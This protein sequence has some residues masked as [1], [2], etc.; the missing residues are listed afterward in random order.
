MQPFRITPRHFS[1]AVIIL[2]VVMFSAILAY[3]SSAWADSRQMKLL[4]HSVFESFLSLGIIVASASSLYRYFEGNGWNKPILRTLGIATV[5]DLRGRWEGT[6]DREGDHSR[7]FVVE[8]TQ[9]AT[10]LNVT[11]MSDKSSSHSINAELLYDQVPTNVVL[12]YTFD[13]STTNQIHGIDTG[14]F[15]GTTI[16]RLNVN[17]G[18]R[19]LQ[20]FYYTNRK[21][22]Q[23]AGVLKVT[24]KQLAC[25]GQ[26]YRT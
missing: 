5:P 13:C 23:T 7:G 16:L 18:V 14:H 15:Y 11:T 26:F 24:W 1:I 22:K 4:V 3:R 17:Q 21:P 9:S 8:I 20:G 12:L 19:T 6:L 2:T 10:R 25:I